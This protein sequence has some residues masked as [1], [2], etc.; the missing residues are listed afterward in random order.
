MAGSQILTLVWRRKLLFAFVSALVFSSIIAA[1]IFW[2]KSYV[3][4]AKILFE[5]RS[6]AANVGTK[7]SAIDHPT[8]LATQ[9][10]VLKSSRVAIRVIEDLQMKSNK[11]AVL[12]YQQERHDNE[13]FN[14]FNTEHLKNGLTVEASQE[15]N[16]ID[17]S[18]RANDPVFA[19]QAA[20]AFVKAFINV[21]QDLREIA[22]KADAEWLEKQLN[23]VD[24]S[25]SETQNVRALVSAIHY[26][27]LIESQIP[28]SNAISLDEALPPPRP[29]SPKTF[30]GLAAATILAPLFGLLA[31]L[32]NEALDRRVRSRLDLEETTGVNV[33]CVVGVGRPSRTLAVFRTMTNFVIPRPRSRSS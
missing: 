22:S 16:V 13:T 4:T 7:A 20:N 30:P 27:K 17:V 18:Y 28:M 32:L 5:T 12:R 29:S 10:D 15:G 3:A 11:N 14:Q 6:V 31:V 1:I 33:L 25:L 24:K 21:S 23:G 9:V 2:P 8:Y 19:A 26:Q